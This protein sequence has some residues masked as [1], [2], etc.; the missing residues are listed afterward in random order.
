MPRRTEQ[1]LGSSCSHRDTSQAQGSPYGADE[2]GAGTGGCGHLG[3]EL[4]LATRAPK[5][6][7]HNAQDLDLSLSPSQN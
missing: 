5:Q 3:A 4:A 7:G 2:F 1:Q 6:G